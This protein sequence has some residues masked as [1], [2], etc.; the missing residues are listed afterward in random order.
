MVFGIVRESQAV[1]GLRHPNIVQVYD[2]GDVDGRSYFTMEFIEGGTEK[3]KD[4][5]RENKG[6][7]SLFFDN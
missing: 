3:D 6:V 5:P 1:A 2:V 7:G 4:K